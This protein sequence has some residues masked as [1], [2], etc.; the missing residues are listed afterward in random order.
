MPPFPQP[1]LTTPFGKVSAID[2]LMK[3]KRKKG[4]KKVT[5]FLFFWGFLH[6]LTGALIYH[7][8][9]CSCSRYRE[10]HRVLIFHP[11][12]F[13][14]NKLNIF[15]YS[16]LAITK[17]Q[18]HFHS[19]IPGEFLEK[20][21]GEIPNII[22]LLVNRFNKIHSA[23]I[24]NNEKNLFHKSESTIS[25]ISI[26]AYSIIALRSL[27]LLFGILYHPQEK[28]NLQWKYHLLALCICWG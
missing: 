6:T 16:F 4:K 8:G 7:L 14:D 25:C 11:D 9:C 17:S 18:S 15:F 27:S 28:V 24:A 21:A 10:D 3:L 20:Q 2:N 22:C 23:K 12:I 13:Q 19:E 5:D 26:V 1:W